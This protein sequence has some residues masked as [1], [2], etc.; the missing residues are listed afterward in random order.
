[1]ADPVRL[2][3]LSLHPCNECGAAP[4]V[5]WYAWRDPGYHAQCSGCAT[6]ED[7]STPEALEALWNHHH[8][9]TDVAHLRNSAAQ[10][11]AQA[12]QV[13][14]RKAA[15]ASLLT[16]RL[17][18]DVLEMLIYAVAAYADKNEDDEYEND[19]D[20]ED[21]ITWCCRMGNKPCPTATIAALLEESVHD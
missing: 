3:M 6:W 16:E 2:A 1:M 11:A 7:A 21:F 15:S 20:P 4:E 13:A 19:F 10:R 9:S 18:P 14:G 17:T 12:M 8:P 5:I